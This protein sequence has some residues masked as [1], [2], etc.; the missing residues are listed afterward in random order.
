MNPY[1]T[2]EEADEYLNS[3][4][5]TDD[6]FMMGDSD[7]QKAINSAT[8]MIN[9]LSFIGDKTDASQENEFPRNGDLIVP[10]AIKDACCEIALKLSKG[11]DPEIEQENL[12]VVQSAFASVKTNYDRTRPD[13]YVVAGIP[14]ATAWRLLQQ[15]LSYSD[16]ARVYR[17]N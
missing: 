8:K 7:K 17:L 6:W 10:Q 2:L 4:F 14:S 15:Y 5:N 3:I 13:H 16:T 11:Y 12:N 1:V 9:V